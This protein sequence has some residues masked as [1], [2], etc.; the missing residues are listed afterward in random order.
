MLQALQHFELASL[1]LG[2]P[3]RIGPRVVPLRSCA[4]LITSLWGKKRKL[5]VC[6]KCHLHTWKKV[7]STLFHIHDYDRLELLRLKGLEPEQLAVVMLRSCAIWK[8]SII[9]SYSITY[10]N[11]RYKFDSGTSIYNFDLIYNSIYFYLINTV[12]PWH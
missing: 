8:F 6:H 9:Y 10:I 11:H 2:L 4:C 3:D 7:I 12:E 5:L 1:V